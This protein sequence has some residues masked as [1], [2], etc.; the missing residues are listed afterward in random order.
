MAFLA[1]A[2]PVELLGLQL[3]SVLVWWGIAGR[4]APPKREVEDEPR[5]FLPKLERCRGCSAELAAGA[6]FCEGCGGRVA[7]E[8][9]CKR[10][11]ETSSA[12]A[13]FCRG[14]GSSFGR[15]KRPSARSTSPTLCAPAAHRWTAAPFCPAYGPDTHAALITRHRRPCCHLPLGRRPRGPRRAAGS[16]LV[17]GKRAADCRCR[18]AP[19]PTRSTAEAHPSHRRPSL[20]QLRVG[21]VA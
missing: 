17:R 18:R 6:K 8:R 3:V 13:Q 12:G 7:L 20:G 15:R 16:P 5:P 11:G 4:P 1:T 2:Q 21:R 9:V 14:C 10:C 19:E